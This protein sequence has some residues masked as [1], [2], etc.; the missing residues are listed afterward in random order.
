M[1]SY[2]A[3]YWGGVAVCYN[4]LYIL[5]GLKKHTAKMKKI[6]ISLTSLLLPVSVLAQNN[7]SPI[8]SAKDIIE[9]FKKFLYWIATAFWIWAVIAIIYAGFL[10][11]TAAGDSEK[12][13]KAKKQLLYSVIAVAIGLVAYGVPA[14]VNSILNRQ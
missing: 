6:K 1:V 11:L 14:I 4:D 9:L 5:K 3:P 8:N 2:P 10:Y 12:L 7:Q 13:D